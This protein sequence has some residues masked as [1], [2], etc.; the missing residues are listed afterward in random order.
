ML[1]A[2]D[3]N[4]CEAKLERELPMPVVRE[5]SISLF[6]DGDA[7]R[8]V[9]C[10][11]GPTNTTAGVTFTAPGAVFTFWTLTE[12][13]VIDPCLDMDTP[14]AATV[15]EAPLQVCGGDITRWLCG[16]SRLRARAE[17][18]GASGTTAADCGSRIVARTAVCVQTDEPNEV[19]DLE[20]GA[21]TEGVRLQSSCAGVRVPLDVGVQ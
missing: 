6:G 20:S 5:P 4:D 3:G 9:G 16:L 21:L 7:C 17:H 13:T 2:V 15:N 18:F 12:V 14:A 19:H 10:E 8:I 1:R 11:V